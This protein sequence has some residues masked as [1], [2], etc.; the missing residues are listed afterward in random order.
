MN[1][2]RHFSKSSAMSALFIAAPV[3]G[4]YRNGW[5]FDRLAVIYIIT[6][7]CLLGAWRYFK[8]RL[9]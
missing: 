5:Q 7:L 2:A 6:G 9:A 3:F 1:G 8:D 4:F